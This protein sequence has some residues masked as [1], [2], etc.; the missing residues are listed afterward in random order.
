[1]MNSQSL[2]AVVLDAVDH[3]RGTAQTPHRRSRRLQAT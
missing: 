3:T 1:M 2:A